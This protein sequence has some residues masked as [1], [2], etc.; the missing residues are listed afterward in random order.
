M[1][2]DECEKSLKEEKIFPGSTFVILVFFLGK[3]D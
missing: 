3:L 2:P 1:G